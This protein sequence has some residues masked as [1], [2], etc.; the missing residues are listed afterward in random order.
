M[1]EH[2]RAICRHCHFIP[3]LYRAGS[4]NRPAARLRQR[5]EGAPRTTAAATKTVAQGPV[6]IV[7]N[8]DRQRMAIKPQVEPIG[9]G[10]QLPAWPPR[11]RRRLRQWLLP[12]AHAWAGR[13]HCARHRPKRVIHRPV[14]RAERLLPRLPGIYF[15]V[16]K[17]TVSGCR[18][19]GCLRL[20]PR[21]LRPPPASTRY[22]RW[23]FCLT[24]AIPTRI[25]A[26]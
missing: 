15:A 13:G 1:A 9:G 14:Q 11:A 21:W 25:C 2:N 16:K 6:C 23:A 10:N 8:T 18:Q 3:R 19:R 26:S 5:R 24:A 20:R 4:S 7:R 17:R 12:V 22:S